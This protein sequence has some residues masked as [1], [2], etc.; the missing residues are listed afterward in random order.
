MTT[1]SPKN[2]CWQ[3]QDSIVENI[4]A[5]VEMAE[6]NHRHEGWA[7]VRLLAAAA[8]QLNIDLAMP[9]KWNPRGNLK[10]RFLPPP[11]PPPNWCSPLCI[12]L[13]CFR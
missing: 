2:S 4:K 10:G 6:A 1:I 11:P 12:S 13:P 3:V 7:M 8:A 5:A 9:A